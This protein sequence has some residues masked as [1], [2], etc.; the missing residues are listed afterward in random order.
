VNRSTIATR[1]FK[2]LSAT[3]AV[4]A[5]LGLSLVACGDDSSSGGNASDDTST[6]SS[7]TPS[8]STSESAAPALT[9][10][11]CAS[12]AT[13]DDTFVAGGILPL[14]GNLAFLGPPEISGVGLAVSDINAAGG[15][16]GAQA[17]HNILDSGDSTD[18]SISTGSANT[19]VSQKPSVVIGAASS[20]V[21]LNFVDTLTDA[22]ITQVSP[23]NTAV[24]LSG[25]SP[26]YFRTAPP[27]TVQGNALGT[28]ISSDGY[29]NIGFLVFNDTYG[30]GL[31]NSVQSTIEGASGKCVYGCKGDGDEFPA[32]QTTFSAEVQA[33]NAANPDAIV[34]IAFD[35]TKSIVPELASSGFDM[36]KTYFVDGNLSDYS[37]DFEAGTLEGAQGTLPGQDPDQGFKDRLSGWHESSAGDPLTVYSY[38]AESYDATILA[39]LAATK[40]GSNDSETVD[41][42]FAAV[43]GA[44]D[45]E[46]CNTYAD[47]LALIDEGKEIRYAGPSGI[48]PIDDEND[49]S[50]AFI[51]IYQYGADNTFSLSTTVEGSKP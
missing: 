35:E 22:K 10:D 11:K 29:T 1:R 5:A 6:S 9:D 40:G 23:A 8:E 26:F 7:S 32:G 3:V 45:G 31:R 30:T 4:G 39:A 14:T 21:S 13:S 16:N 41:K 33:V 17:C 38:G 49:P 44:T 2:R 18:L 25:Y 37:A 46:E 50:S 34:I 27:D 47:C 19:L 24:D 20:S 48:G 51:G 15:V 36:S 43:S 28:L 12:G 42:N